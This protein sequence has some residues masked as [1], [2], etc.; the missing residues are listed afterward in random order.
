MHRNYITHCRRLARRVTSATEVEQPIIC[1]GCAYPYLVHPTITAACTPS[2]Q[3]I[4]A[5]LS[6]E[7]HPIAGDILDAVRTFVSDGRS[8]FFGRDVTLARHE[9]GRLCELVHAGHQQPTAHTTAAATRDERLIAPV[10]AG[11]HK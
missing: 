6:E 1:P 3:A 4:A 7:R 9:A 10:L 8:S 2:L 5:T 11:S